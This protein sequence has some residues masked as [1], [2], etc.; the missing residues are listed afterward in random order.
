MSHILF[1]VHHQGRGHAQRTLAIAHELPAN[2]RIT[3]MTARPS[4][5]DGF[6]RDLEVIELPDMIGAPSRTPALYDHPTPSVMHCVPL[7]VAEQRRTMAR[8]AETLDRVDPSLFVI[9]VSAEIALL[10]RILSVPAVKIRMHGDRLDPGHLAAYEACAGMFAPFDEELEQPDYPDWARAKTFYSGGL[11]T[12]ETPVA[13]RAAARAALGLPAEK[14]LVVVV[15]GGG[16]SGTP[17]APLTMAARAAP[18]SEFHVLGPVHRE[19]HETDFA[20]LML[21]GWVD[22]ITDWLA[23]AD[24]VI[25]NAGDNLVHEIA[26][27]GRPFLCVPEWRYFDE[28]VQK[29][30][31]LGRLGAA[32]VLNRWPGSLTAWQE[33]LAAAKTIDLERQRT[34]FD[35]DA[36]TKAANWLADTARDLWAAPGSS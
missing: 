10:A 9:D 18:R 15:A 2:V 30:E 8:I 1:F 28:Q 29:A 5:F 34:L 16:G 14:Q 20:N 11:C 4:L 17:Y 23:A 13:E 35:P 26:R 3:A 22:G 6:S 27:I 32:H 25:A 31:Q 33:E 36:A 21:H 12:T 24:I 7:G 19:G